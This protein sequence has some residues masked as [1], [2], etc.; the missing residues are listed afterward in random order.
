MQWIKK[1]RGKT[2]VKQYFGT[3]PFY[4]KLLMLMLPIMVQNGITNFV[5]MLDN[6]MVGQV[7]TAEMTGVAVS[8]QL[9]FVFNLCIFGAVSGAGIFGAQFFGKNDH[10]G[11]RHTFRF[12]LIFGAL[13]TAVC[14]TLFLIFGDPLIGLYLQGESGEVNAADILPF[15][16]RYMWIMLVGLLPYTVV[17]CYSSTLRETGN[18]V[19]PMLAG[20]AAVA[21]NLALNWVL[22]FGNLGAPK[23]GV[24]GA[25]I[26]T[27]ISRFVELLIVTIWAHK[28]TAKNPFVKGVYRSVY[29]PMPLVKGILAKGTPLLLNETFW[30]AGIA[31][32]NQCYSVRSV[33]DVSAL[34]IS[35][36]FFNVFSVAFLSVGAAIGILL[37]Q[38]LGAGE[39]EKAR[40][41]ARILIVFSLLVS[42]AVSVIYFVCAFWIPGLYNVAPSIRNTATHLMQIA[43]LAMPLDAFANASYF[44]LRS[45]G[46]TFITILFDSCFVWLIQ[47]PTAFCLSRYTAVPIL[48]LFGVCHLLNSLKCVVGYVLV[49]RGIWIRNIVEEPKQRI[50]TVPSEGV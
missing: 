1:K 45:G 15:A 28:N 3:W 8:N 37:G 50:D 30:A 16:R 41:T 29:V 27:V 32:L 47:V 42:V 35:Q 26:A 44:T 31:M 33:D 18:A 4:K 43:A 22:I 48:V 6:I 39:T 49:K 34:N 23:L 36:T 24:D 17:Q 10:D 12:K 20:V 13:L 2:M 11:V 40:A 9:F 25:A 14:V 46:K 38:Q 5:N 19:V 21:V 7:G